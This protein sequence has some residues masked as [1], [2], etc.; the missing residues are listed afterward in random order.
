MYYH[1]TTLICDGSKEYVCTG[2]DYLISLIYSTNQFVRMSIN[3]QHFVPH[4]HYRN[5][6]HKTMTLEDTVVLHLR[7]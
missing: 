4:F 7:R 5:K 2:I 1:A 6:Y 3:C